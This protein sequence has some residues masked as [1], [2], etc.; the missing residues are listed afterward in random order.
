MKAITK[1]FVLPPPPQPPKPKIPV[2]YPWESTNL[3]N[4]CVQLY[5]LARKTG[6]NDTFDE[7]K[8]HFG[9]YLNSADSI[10]KVDEYTGQY[11]VTPLPNVEQI[12]RTE[13]KRLTEDVVVEPIPY[14]ETSNDAGGYTVIIG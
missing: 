13:N 8:A 11:S 3:Y 9:A 2:V 7:F 6:Y 1:Q 14:Y 5:D 4:L 12:L 10:I